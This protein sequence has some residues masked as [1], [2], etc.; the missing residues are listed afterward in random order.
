[1]QNSASPRTKPIKIL[2]LI[3]GL[4]AG[5][6]ERQ[7]ATLALNSDP[8]RARHEIVSLLDDGIWGARLRAAGTPVHT[9]KMTR[10]WAAPLVLPR[11]VRLCRSSGADIVQSWLYHADLMGLAVAALS[12]RAAIWT[13]RA[14]NLRFDIYGLETR[15]LVRLLAGLSSFPSAIVANAAEGERWHRSIGYRPR[16]FVVIP[17][18]IDCQSF[19]PDPEAR[20]SVRRELALPD[21]ALLVG[22]LS[23]HDPMKDHPTLL[24][25]FARV[26]ER[27]WLLLAGDGTDIRN[28]AL[29]REIAAAGI[30]PARILRLG[31]REDVPRLLAALDVAVLSSWFGEGFPN[32]VAEAMACGVP[33]IGTDIGDT[34][35]VIGD[36]GTVVAPGDVSGLAAALARTVALDPAARAELGRRSR[37]RIETQFSVPAM[38]EGY[39]SLYRQVLTRRD[40]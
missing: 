20:I 18:G 36:C 33:S 19:A 35:R 4:G 15:I 6:A 40:G 17:N 5:G 11:L 37:A 2:H 26:A 12:G 13:L 28:Q 7:L 25:S 29:D 14:S 32:I 16:R 8:N 31:L 9:L 27:S 34:A 10:K 21:N 39:Y 1:M 23:R 30:P 38:V 22:N 24:A 3:T